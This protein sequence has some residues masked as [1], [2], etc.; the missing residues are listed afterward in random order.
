MTFVK[1][2]GFRLGTSLHYI[3]YPLPP[4]CC[5]AVTSRFSAIDQELPGAPSKELS[6]RRSDL[7]GNCG[8]GRI[9]TKSRNPSSDESANCNLLSH[10]D[11]RIIHYTACVRLCHEKCP[12]LVGSCP[13]S[14]KQKRMPAWSF[15]GPRQ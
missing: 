11:Q 1:R 4:Y 15:L 9:S 5:R 10:Q 2:Q 13:L 7:R 14:C 12:R 8:S 3:P 6:A